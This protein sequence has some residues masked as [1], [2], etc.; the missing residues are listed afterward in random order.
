LRA[1]G[2]QQHAACGT[3][4][5]AGRPLLTG[6]ETWPDRT[7]VVTAAGEV[8]LTNAEGLRDAL[9]SALD[10]GALGLVADLTTSTFLD[11]AGISALVPDHTGHLPARAPER[12]GAKQRQ[13]TV[14]DNTT[15]TPPGLAA[16][17]T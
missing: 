5:P 11:S 14:I 12:P 4:P 10:A 6:P 2:R 15:R 3:R 7:A 13:A 9:F 8:D 17:D 1:A 16:T